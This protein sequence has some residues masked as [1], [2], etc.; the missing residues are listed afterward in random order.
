MLQQRKYQAAVTTC[1]AS[2]DRDLD[3]QAGLATARAHYALGQ[4]D[5]AVI[6]PQR[7]AGSPEEAA[8]WDVAADARRRRKEPDLEKE[9]RQ[10]AIGLYRDRRDLKPL[11]RSQYS[12]FYSSWERSDFLLAFTSARDAYD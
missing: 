11:A 9:A 2:F 10:K 3:P 8:G 7:L 5:Q 12:L 4:D 1:Q 6:W